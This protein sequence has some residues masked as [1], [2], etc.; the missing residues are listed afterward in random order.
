MVCT[1]KPGDNANTARPIGTYV[2]SQATTGDGIRA[3]PYSYNMTIDPHTYSDVQTSGG[4]VHTIGEVWCSALWDM[5]WLM[6][7]KYGYDPDIYTGTGGNNKSMKLVIDGL[8]MQVCSP[9]FLDS[10]DAIL[11]ADTIDN[12][13]ANSCLIWSAFAR[14]GMGFSAVQGS[15]DNTNDQTAAFDLP[16]AC[17]AVVLPVTLVSLKASGIDNKINVAWKTEIEYNN[18][19]F[20]L[21]RKSSLS[22]P[23][24]TIATIAA[25]GNNGNGAD[26]TFDDTN[27]AANVLYY[28]Q[29]IQKDKDGKKNFSQVVT[30]I[31]HKH[32]PFECFSISQSRR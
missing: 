25:K 26:Y 31:I 7:N 6:I 20:E 9:G 22:E 12:A 16:T 24:V 23:F 5:Y 15:S 4:E 11:S 17:A 21:Q 14:R 27:V 8:K 32:L 30:A 10:R 2:A 13:A 1:Q 28:Y 29:L 18:A 3:H 19:G